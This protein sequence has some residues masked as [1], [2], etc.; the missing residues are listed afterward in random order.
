MKKKFKID[1]TDRPSMVWEV[2]DI[3]RYQ[4]SD[5][6]YEFMYGKHSYES[7]DRLKGGEYEHLYS[8]D[9]IDRRAHKE[10]AS[11]SVKKEIRN[12]GIDCIQNNAI[13]IIRIVN[14]LRL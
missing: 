2:V 13:S 10:L 7:K 9:D 6:L 12:L 11:E 3:Q 4:I 5:E 8:L 14:L 1:N